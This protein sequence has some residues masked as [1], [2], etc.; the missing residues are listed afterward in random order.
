[1]EEKKFINPECKII[2]F[3]LEDIITGS[4]WDMNDEG[5]PDLDGNN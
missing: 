2:N 5:T 3:S 1:M 4:N